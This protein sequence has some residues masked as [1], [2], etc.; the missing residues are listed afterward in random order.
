[1][2]V[3][4]VAGRNRQAAARLAIGPALPRQNPQY[5]W[6]YNVVVEP[7]GQPGLGFGR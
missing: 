7:E 4:A 5:R 1:M 6:N 3:T 2:Q